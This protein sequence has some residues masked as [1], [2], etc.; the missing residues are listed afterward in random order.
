MREEIIKLYTIDELSEGARE[1]A[2]SEMSNINVD[3]E[4][5]E[6]VLD[7]AKT[8]GL[9]IDEF[10]IDRKEINGT[11]TQAAVDVA[12]TIIR[13]HGESCD[14]Y[15]TAKN[16]L[17]EIENK[18][19]DLD[20][21]TDEEQEDY[22]ALYAEFEYSLLQDYLSALDKDYDYL[23]SEE[24]ILETIRSNGYEFTEDGKLY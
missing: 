19:Y 6:F 23:T 8:I 17:A 14:T 22:D 7:D 11:F 4:W 9:L 15:K 12:A 24:A 21:L 18:G 1:K 20:S 10:S 5:W 2:V 3:Y 13:E 16:F